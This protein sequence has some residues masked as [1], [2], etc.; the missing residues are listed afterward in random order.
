MFSKIFK[1]L[2]FLFGLT[3]LVGI[4]WATYLVVIFIAHGLA[5]LKSDLAVSVVAASASVIV[6]MLTLVISK[7]LETR[8]VIT[9]ELRAKKTPIYEEFIAT[10]YKVLFAEKLGQE[11]MSHAELMSFFASYTE[12]LTIWGVRWCN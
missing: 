5:K 7:R 2:Q 10:L 9:Q 11:S 8:T 1:L 3:L 6:A 12:K 4:G